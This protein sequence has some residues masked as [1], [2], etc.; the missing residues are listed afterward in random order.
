VPYSYNPEATC[1]PIQDWLLEMM[2][3]DEQ[4]VKLLRA[5]MNAVIK[6]RSDIQ[7]FLECIGEGG[8]GKS[9][10]AN[11][12]IALIGPQN[13]LSTS[14]KLLE[15]NR[16]ES[17]N[18]HGKR[19]VY[20]ADSERYTRNASKLKALTGGDQI[21]YERKFVQGGNSFRFKGMVLIVANEAI[22]FN[23]HTNGTQRRRITVPF[24]HRVS[25]NDRRNLIEILDDGITVGDFAPYI[26]GLLNWVL[27]MPDDEVTGLIRDTCQTVPSL[28]T[29]TVENLLETNPMASW[30][31]SCV[32]ID[33]AAKVY[34]GSKEQSESTHLYPNYVHFCHSH[35]YKPVTSARFSQLLLG[36]LRSQLNLGDT[37]KT[38]DRQGN[39]ITGISLR[40]KDDDAP[41]PFTDGFGLGDESTTP[42]I[43]DIQGH[44]GCE[45]SEQLSQA[46]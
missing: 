13:T 31:D 27:A 39:Y 9:T 32:V 5:Y 21:R 35:G 28:K 10:F 19:L 24:S 23:D 41:R 40:S 7:R 37:Q 18:L 34:V 33:S 29:A 1:E 20:I 11:L 22:Q 14:L 36:L 2:Q 17:A 26:P 3:G 30:L 12:L 38:H 15:T 45:G 25:P 6:S 43:L 42:E 8:T 46:A 16:F 44:E 4:K